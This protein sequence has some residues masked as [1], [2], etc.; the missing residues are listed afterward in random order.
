MAIDVDG[1]RRAVARVLDDQVEV[2]RDSGGH[3]DDLLDERTGQLVP[4]VPE[5]VLVWHGL[6]AVTPVGRP[7]ITKP[8]DGAIVQEPPGAQYQAVLPVEA[9]VRPD[10][11]LRV[12][13]S[14]PSSRPRDPQLLGRRFRVSDASVGSYS[15]V[16][17]V[18]LE[19]LS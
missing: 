9:Q 3:A 7:A 5:E 12:A 13:R 16:R 2:W 11:I 4:P 19:V 10:D 17:I 6:G 8:V 15:V 18:R 1:A 14:T